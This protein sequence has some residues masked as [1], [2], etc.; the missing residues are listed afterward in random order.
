[1]L[2]SLPLSREQAP[3]FL[4]FPPPLPKSTSR[5]FF[6]SLMEFLDG[7]SC[8]ALGGIDDHAAAGV[9]FFYSPF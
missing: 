7:P 5:L 1:M 4:L 9:L 8:N 2:K 6:S 3:S